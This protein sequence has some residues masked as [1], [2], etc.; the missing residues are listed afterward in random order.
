M[1]TV[2]VMFVCLGN[3][4]RSPAGEGIMRSL[5]NKHG[6][7]RRIGIESCGMGDWHKGEAADQRMAEAA[8]ARGYQL[9]SR[10][11][12]FQD[13]FFDTFDYLLAADHSIQEQLLQKARSESDRQRIF[14]MTAFSNRYTNE[15][16]PDPYYGGKQGF[17][18]VMMILEDS[19]LGLIE[20]I[21][22]Q[23]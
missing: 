17:E 7:E 8:S 22:T 4:C 19:C 13:T 1:K 5:V 23:L 21:K 16:V 10:A 20:R 12:A 9:L 2:S 3:I 18:L 14:M 6:L 11:Q 15:E